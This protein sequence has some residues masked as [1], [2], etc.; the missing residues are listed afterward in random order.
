MRLVHAV[1]VLGSLFLAACHGQPVIDTTPKPSVGGTIAGI[2]STDTNTPLA[3][4]KVSA[5][6]VKTGRR[7]DATTGVNGGYTIKVPEGTYRL[8]FQLQSGEAVAKQP[9][10]TKINNSDLDPHRDFV[11]TVKRAG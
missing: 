5:V 2:V 11:I 6:D 10:D 1:L 9:D 3:N 8:E 7:F 4:R